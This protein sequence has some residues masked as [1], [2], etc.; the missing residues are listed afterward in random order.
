[1][2]RAMFHV[3]RALRETGQALDRLGLRAQNNLIFQ[4][5]SACAIQARALC[6]SFLRHSNAHPPSCLLTRRPHPP[7]ARRA[8]SAGTVR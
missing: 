6:L 2:R 8:Q 1:M 3:G 4:E 5:K 7:R